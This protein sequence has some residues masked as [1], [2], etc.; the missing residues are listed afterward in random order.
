[1]PYDWKI[2]VPALTLS[3][4]FKPDSHVAPPSAEYAKALLVEPRPLA[5]IN[6]PLVGDVIQ[7]RTPM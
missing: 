3:A 2:E 7:Y 6:S 1:M 5:P 4:I